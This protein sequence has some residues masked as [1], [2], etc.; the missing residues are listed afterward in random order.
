MMFRE[1]MNME[2]Q[3]WPGTEFL[4]APGVVFDFQFLPLKYEFNF[5]WLIKFHQDLKAIIFLW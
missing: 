3:R 4:C 1:G 5:A 2:I